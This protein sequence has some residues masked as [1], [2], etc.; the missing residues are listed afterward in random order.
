[1]NLVVCRDHLNGPPRLVFN[2]LWEGNIPPETRRPGCEADHLAL[3]I[4]EVK[5]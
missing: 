1:M 5:T 4:A 2:V 3:Y